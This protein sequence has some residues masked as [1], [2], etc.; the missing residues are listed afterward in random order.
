MNKFPTMSSSPDHSYNRLDGTESITTSLDTASLPRPLPRNDYLAKHNSTY[1]PHNRLSRYATALTNLVPIRF[2]RTPGSELPVDKIGL[3]SSVSFSW[4]NEYLSAGC[5]NGMRNKALPT[6][7]AQDSCQINGPRLD[8]LW[9]AHVVE[10]GQAGAS[11]PRIAWKF[12]RTRVLMASFIYMLG[13]L[14]SLIGPIFLLQGIISAIEDRNAIYNNTING[15]AT[16]PNHN[17]SSIVNSSFKNHGKAL[18]DMLSESATKPSVGRGI[19]N[20]LP[21]SVKHLIMIDEAIIFCNIIVLIL[22]EIISYFL[23]AWSSTLNLRTASRLRSA[24]LALVYKKLIH[25]S[26]RYRASA[27]QTITYFV[28]DSD[29]LYELITN[30]PLIFTGPIILILISLFVWHLMGNWALISI[31]VLILFYLCLI[32]TAYL[33]SVFATKTSDYSLTRMSLVEEFVSNI[34]LAKMTLWD[35]CFRNKI[36]DVRKK[37][38][39]EMRLGG[40]SEGWSLSMV[41]FI[42][43]ITVCTATIARLLTMKYVE[44]ADYMVMLVILLINLKQCVR[45]SWLAMSSISRGSTSLNKLKTVLMLKEADRYPDKPIDKNL[46][47]T[48]NRGNFKWEQDKQVVDSPG[49]RTSQFYLENQDGPPIRFNAL[50]VT[51]TLTDINFYAPKGK[52]IG[53]CGQPGSGKSSL[54]LALMGHLHH[55]SGHVTRDGTCSYVSETPWLL[56]GTLKENIIFGETFDSNRYYK[57]LQSCQLNA[58]I[59]LLPASDDTDL[60]EVN[61][62]PAQKQRITLAR[63]VYARRDINLLDNPLADV[64][65]VNESNQI[66]EKCFL[67]A[68]GRKTV[69]MVSEKIQFLNRCDTIYVMREG[70][71][72]EQGSHEELIRWDSEYIRLIRS[73]MKKYQRRYYRD[74]EPISPSS[75]QLLMIATPRG[76]LSSSSTNASLDS[77][78]DE[79]DSAPLKHELNSEFPVKFSTDAKK[80]VVE[81]GLY[82]K[83]SGGWFKA[84]FICTI[85]MFCAFIIAVGPLAFAYIAERTIDDNV[86]IMIVFASMVGS[87]ILFSLILMLLY[88]NAVFKAAKKLHCQWINGLY[89]AQMSLFTMTPISVLLNTCSLN[90]Y[91]VD[92]V[93]PRSIITILMHAGISMFSSAILGLVSPWLLIPIT[94]FVIAAISYSLYV[95]GAITGLY[96]VKVNSAIPMYNHA[97]NTIDG[98]TTIQAY[99]KEKDF[100]KKFYR[101]CDHNSTYNFMLH[102]IKLWMEYRIKLLGALT[103][104]AVILICVILSSIRHR[105]ELM[106]LATICTLQLVA[107]TVSITGASASA[108]TSFM[109]ITGLDFYV[110]NIPKEIPGNV[111]MPTNWPIDASIKFENVTLSMSVNTDP[112]LDTLNFEVASGEKIALIGSQTNGKISIVSALYKFIEVH[113]GKICIGNTNISDVPMDKLRQCITFIPGDPLLFN[114]SIKYNLDPMGKVSEKELMVALQRVFLWEKVSKLEEKLESD[115]TNCF[116]AGER[117]LIFFARVILRKTIKIMII[118]ESVTDL[119][120]DVEKKIEII[121]RDIFP[122]HTV[123]VLSTQ[124]VRYCQR[125]L[126]LSNGKINESANRKSSTSQHSLASSEV[127]V[128]AAMNSVFETSF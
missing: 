16:I 51:H 88:N 53:I 43:V 86:H 83:N 28:P 15:T 12:V 23:I 46:A 6:A 7:A 82:V 87:M 108:Y 52:L 114:G 93:L 27:Y 125:T 59:T 42:P 103:L 96:E 29:T 44:S 100:K 37:E 48:V 32:L 2:K 85:S 124:R 118:E 91:E 65:D 10:R 45:S 39:V 110:E 112:D 99:H 109:A 97:F 60:T 20:K 80:P 90:L 102:A 61:L 98:R 26:V 75:A 77:M 122:D 128:T 63:A 24:C 73:Y 84:I 41:H 50:S 57:A 113:S 104:G 58:D 70:R 22:A 9:H 119:G 69:I 71:I 13:T 47:I 25:S 68:M 18:N 62:S 11:V 127:L 40:L 92:S 78:L 115:A 17:S 56:E 8:G 30:G 35:N 95:R 74:G 81:Y 21:D 38:L 31:V 121:L 123:I 49:K 106:V 33:T 66:F 34:H 4:L 3:F 89:T 5:K 36:E 111:S 117:K 120:P 107:S 101:Y 72:V 126:V 94:L 19:I 116:T 54:L 1:V 67:E 14:I 79:E 76:V 55:I 64:S 105:F